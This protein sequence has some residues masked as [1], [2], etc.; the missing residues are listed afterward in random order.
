M[1]EINEVQTVGMKTACTSTLLVLI[2]K[3]TLCHY[4]EQENQNFHHNENLQ[5]D[6]TEDFLTQTSILLRQ[7][8]ASGCKLL[9][10]NLISDSARS[11]ISNVT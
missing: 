6:E 8:A 9:T 2:H 4:T 1:A 11:R 3:S 10:E 5:P 7:N